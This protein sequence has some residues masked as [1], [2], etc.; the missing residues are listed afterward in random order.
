MCPDASFAER[1][2]CYWFGPRLKVDEKFVYKEGVVTVSVSG[3]SPY[4]LGKQIHAESLEDA[5]HKL[6]SEL[7]CSKNLLARMYLQWSKERSCT[8]T[9]VYPHQE[10]S[11]LAGQ[12]RKALPLPS[13]IS[14]KDK[15]SCRRI[16]VAVKAPCSRDS[17]LDVLRNLC[18]PLLASWSI[19]ALQYIPQSETP[20]CQEFW[21]GRGDSLASLIGA[22]LLIALVSVRNCSSEKM[23]SVIRSQLP[24]SMDEVFF[25]TER[26]ASSIFSPDELSIPVE[27]HLRSVSFLTM[28]PRQGS[29]IIFVTIKL[30]SSSM[31]V[32]LT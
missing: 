29:Q 21:N 24:V 31:A 11:Y 15:T 20:F 27:D 23:I 9:C 32:S 7:S 19:C 2:L 3:P 25:A 16:L 4:V 18:F 13:P 14:S 12:V 5:L 8:L 17:F 1:D 10:S 28:K 22:N 6:E 26:C 30:V